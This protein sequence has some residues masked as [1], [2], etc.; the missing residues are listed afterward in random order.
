M[1]IPGDSSTT[2]SSGWPSSST[3]PTSGPSQALEIPTHRR[4]A[5]QRLSTTNGDFVNI[6][7]DEEWDGWLSDDEDDFFNPESLSHIAVK[8]RDRVQRNVHVKGGLRYPNSFTGK[9]IVVRH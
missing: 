2:Y 1:P 5:S 9:D 8:L 3:A 4:R 7:S 6:A